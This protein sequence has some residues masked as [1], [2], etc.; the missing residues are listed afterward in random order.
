MIS[1]ECFRL[2]VSMDL[3]MEAIFTTLG[4]FISKWQIPNSNYLGKIAQITENSR[5]GI[6][7][8]LW[9]SKNVRNLRVFFTLSTSHLWFHLCWSN[10]QHAAC[11][12]HMEAK[13][14]ARSSRHTSPSQLAILEKRENFYRTSDRIRREGWNWPW[15]TCSFLSHLLRW[16]RNE[17][18]ARPGSYGHPWTNHSGGKMNTVIGQACALRS[19]LDQGLGNGW[20]NSKC[21]RWI[22]HW[23]D[24]VWCQKSKDA[25]DII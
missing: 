23:K 7:T 16:M 3:V 18:L 24:R 14:P 10:S 21:L 20:L 6:E 4:Y 2:L 5:S 1:L 17:W 13:M 25:Q 8:H 11:S 15:V 12:L 19:S 22:S 9:C